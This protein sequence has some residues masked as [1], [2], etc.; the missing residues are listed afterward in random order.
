MNDSP[1]PLQAWIAKNTSQ[2]RFAEAAGLSEPYL[3]EI[4]SGKKT[5][6]LNMAVK[7][8]EAT[9]GVVPIMAFVGGGGAR[10]GAEAAQ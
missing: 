8:S 9:G 2:A 5:P 1:H 6:S 7:L 10:V 4:L 3:S